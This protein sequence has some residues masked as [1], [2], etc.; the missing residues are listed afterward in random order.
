M[1]A[2]RE[3]AYAFVQDV[4]ASWETYGLVAAALGGES[5]DGLILHAAGPTEEGFRIISVWESE[6]D[7]CRFRDERLRPALEQVV[8]RSAVEPTFRELR[9]EHLVD[10][11]RTLSSAG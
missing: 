7:W 10:G 3:L 1:S 5:S 9:V 6:E 11:L 2:R 8:G 4:P